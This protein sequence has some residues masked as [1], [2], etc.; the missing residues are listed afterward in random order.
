MSSALFYV[1][2]VNRGIGY[3]ANPAAKGIAAFRL[4]LDT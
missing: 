1:G 3:V 2:G 4:D